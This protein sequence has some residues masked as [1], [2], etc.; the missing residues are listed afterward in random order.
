MRVLVAGRLALFLGLSLS[1]GVVCAADTEGEVPGSLVK[2]LQARFANQAIGV[3]EALP[4]PGLYRVRV[5][6]NLYHVTADGRYAF[7]GDLLDL[8]S[9][10]NLTEEVR[11]KVR[12]DAIAA[13]PEQDRVVY[14][15]QGETRAVL[16][17]FTDT[18]CGFCRKLHAEV[19]TLQ[20]AGVAVQ[21][22]P[23]ARG[24]NQ[25]EGARQLRAVWCAPDRPAA[26]DIG[27]GVRSGELGSGDCE[28]AK[29]VERGTKLGQELGIRGTPALVLPDGRLQP[30][31]RQASQLLSMLG[32]KP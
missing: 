14:P 10:R 21:Y 16:V 18:T 8:E 27:K 25:S 23:Y 24:G 12:L 7:S 4:V 30:G 9:G 1:I 29:L 26:M 19:P 3:P 32:I 11:G 2:S 28:A 31:Y 13:I 22:I 20:A 15:A 17:A 5:G 6:A